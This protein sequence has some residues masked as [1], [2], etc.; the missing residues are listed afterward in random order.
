MKGRVPVEIIVD[1]SSA[2]QEAIQA[3][4]KDDYVL[5]AGKGHEMYQEIGLVK[6]PYSD[7]QQIRNL[8]E[9]LS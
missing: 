9:K 6:H 2:I 1:R 5:I 7:R 4:G 3:S 8:L